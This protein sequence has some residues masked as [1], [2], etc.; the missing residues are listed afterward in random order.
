MSV[1]TKI[2]GLVVVL[3]AFS[4]PIVY[5][6]NGGTPEA[7][8]HDGDWHHKAQDMHMMAKILNL[9]EDQVKQLKDAKKKQRETMKS[10]FEQ[11]KSNR[12]AFNAEIVKASADMSKINDLQAQLKTIQGQ[13]VDNHLN[14]ILDIKKILTPEQFAGYMALEKARKMMMHQ[15]MHGQFGHKDGDH[16]DWGTKHKDEDND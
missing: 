1:K 11:M 2:T 7:S 13:M 8:H 15:H 3:M 4:V 14:S 5:A 6:D 12:E 16:K 9:S 10:V